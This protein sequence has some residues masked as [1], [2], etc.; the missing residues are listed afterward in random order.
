MSTKPVDF[1]VVGGGPAGCAFAILAARAGASVVLVERDDYRK[2]RPGEHLAG[3]IRPML[4][5]LCVPREDA[6]V[7]A[8]PSPGILSLWN[9]EGPFM[10][11]YGATGQAVGLCVLRHR[12]D[13]L[14][15]RSARK[16]GATVVSCGRPTRIDLRTT[17]T[18][19]VR[20]AAANGRTHDIVAHSVVDASGRSAC[21]ARR[22]G[23]RRINHGDL[24]AIVRWLDIGDLPQ[25]AG[26]ML[27]IESGAYGWWAR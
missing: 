12:F 16:A 10:K 13:E 21:I 1:L 20:I 24:L 27:T 5:A 19:D 23:A 6:G 17:S 22:Q 7:I 18:W 15:C 4:D 14:L 3:R 9:A 11:H 2:L 8:I 26:T 25:C